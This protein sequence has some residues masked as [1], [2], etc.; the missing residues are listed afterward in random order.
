MHK[1]DAG[2][3]RLNLFGEDEVKNAAEEMLGHLGSQH[4]E[5]IHFL[6]QPMAPPGI[7]MVVGVVS[8][9]VFGPVVACGAGGVIVELLKDVSVRITPLSDKDSSEMISSL[10][11]FPLLTGYRGGLRYDVKALEGNGAKGWGF[12]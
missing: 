11:T 2:A 1:T 5:A 10:K 3:V 12:S 7:E 6:V 9:P 8:D 4:F